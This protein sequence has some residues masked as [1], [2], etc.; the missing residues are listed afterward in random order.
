ELPVPHRRPAGVHL[1]LTRSSGQ[2]DFR[3]A[4][5]PPGGRF[6]V[7]PAPLTTGPALEDGPQ[8]A[9]LGGH[10]G[11]TGEGPRRRRDG[12]RRGRG[13]P[14]RLGDDWRCG[15]GRPG[16][17]GGGDRPARGRRSVDETLR[18]RRI[19][20]TPV[21][22]G[23]RLQAGGG[24]GGGP[25]RRPGLVLP[26]S[27]RLIRRRAGRRRPGRHLAGGRRQRS[28]PNP[29]PAL[30][31]AGVDGGGDGA[32]VFDPATDSFTATGP[33]QRDRWYS[34]VVVGPDGGATVFGGA[35]RIGPE[36]PFGQARLTE[37]YDADTDTWEENDAG[38]ASENGLPLQP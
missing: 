18:G 21:R 13:R 14:R 3:T 10:V 9:T 26:R 1:A 38:E 11:P 17:G 16:S 4:R 19:R 34:Q 29:R 2:P 20:S 24:A 12:D 28:G 5:R 23:G 15:S 35:T 30:G 33:M 22:A 25:P 8:A 6:R 31:H 7:R 27:R 36:T 32:V 37:T